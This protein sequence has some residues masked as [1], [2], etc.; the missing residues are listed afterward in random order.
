MIQ[1]SPW[2]GYGMDNWLCH[3]SN[4]P[5]CHTHTFHYMI[6]NDPVTGAPTG[7]QDEPLLSH[8]HNILLHIWVS[9]GIFG[10]LAF[11]ALL[12]LF[13]WLFAHILAHLRAREIESNLYLQWLTIGVGAAMLAAILHGQ[14]DSSFLEQDLSYCFWTLVA[15]LLLLRVLSGTPWRRPKEQIAA[16]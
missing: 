1:G 10:L 6:K 11:I 7:L 15:V 8:P 2:L 9:L 5:L 13:F 12:V 4:N 3:Y 14:V 16:E